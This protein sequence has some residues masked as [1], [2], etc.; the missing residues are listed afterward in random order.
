MG[1]CK[2][3]ACYV[4]NSVLTIHFIIF[5]ITEIY[6]G[7]HLKYNIFLQMCCYLRY[8]EYQ[9]EINVLFV[10]YVIFIQDRSNYKFPNKGVASI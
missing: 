9:M 1:Y 2:Q 6:E 5:T 7:I 3:Y 10:L 4:N 8:P